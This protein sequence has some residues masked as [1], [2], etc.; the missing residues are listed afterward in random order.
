[1]RILYV[2][3]DPG[4]PVFGEKGASIHVRAMVSALH[5]RGHEVVVASP[6]LDPGSGRLPASV[7][8]VTIPPV[9]PRDFE[10]LGEVLAQGARQ[11]TAVREIA[12]ECGA[13]AVYERYSLAACAGARASNSM[14][15]PLVLEVNA[16]LRDEERRFRQLAHE[17]AAL[18]AEQESFAAAQ[19]LIAVSDALADW[20]VS[21]GVDRGRVHVI[22]NA[23]PPRAF[24]A[25]PPLDDGQLVTVGFSGGLKLWHGIE[26][27]ALGFELA[28]AEGARMRLEIVGSG[29][30]SEVLDEVQL[31]E[32]QVVRH[33]HLS[34][35]NALAMLERWD[36]GVAPYMALDRFYFSPLKLVEYMA[37]GLCPVVTNVGQLPQTVQH[38]RA[39]VIVPPGDPAA[40]ARALLALDRDRGRL[41]MLGERARDVVA[42]LPG[43][44]EIADR[45]IGW[46]EE[47]ARAQTGAGE[48]AAARGGGS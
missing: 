40:L 18:L 29:P 31:P 24:A 16:P 37:A 13:E 25:K 41:R 19:V 28:V 46:I 23:P 32:A 33:G 12:S 6:R 44:D 4:I 9:R 10:S 43:W 45:V 36:V 3:A 42:A 21:E 39:G 34:H 26:T 17:P 20:L 48:I 15:I 27:L 1:M 35:D 7:R 47:A 22:G 38:G 30:A 11:T 14:G 5:R 8:C 2:S